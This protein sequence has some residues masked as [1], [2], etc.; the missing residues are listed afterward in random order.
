MKTSK[1]VLITL[2]LFLSII[3]KAQEFDR[4]KM[5]SLFAL[6]ETN[7]K[8]MGSISIFNDGKEAYQNSIGFVSIQDNLKSNRKSK[9]RIGSIS[10]TFTA[11]IIMQLVAK[12]KLSLSSKLSEYYP[13]IENSDGISIE[14][15]LKH[16]SGIFNFTNAED[17]TS[18]MEQPISKE[19]LITK[20]T[21]NGSSFEPNSK[22]EYSNSNYV[23]LSFIA[24]K[25]TS[26]DYSELIQSKICEPCALKNTNYGSFI[27]VK[28][29]EALSYNRLTGWELATE[30]DMSVPVGAGAIISTPT[31]LNLF[32][33][34]L[35]TNKVI[36]QTG[37]D[38]MI[39]I[40]DGYGIGMFKV[41]F[42]D[43]FAFGHTGGIDGFQSNAFYFPN[44]KVSVSYLSNGAV[45]PLN[46]IL[47]GALSIYFGKNYSLPEFAE[48]L[49]LTTEDLDKYL[50]VYS[51]PTFPLKITITKNGSALLAQATGQPY[52]PLEAYEVDK[53]K[54]DQA[55]LKIEFN[56][57]ENLLVLLQG[58][59]TFELKK[60]E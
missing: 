46:D 39:E 57:A 23:L 53:F 45:M 2:L 16:R 50:G 7:Q 41:P 5:D 1:Q 12:N 58:G 4:A 19:E 48:T 37:L 56:P 26:T 29:N 30:T 40:E 43:K 55:M 27:S 3:V 54:F 32:L 33:H 34:C 44:E 59:G 38:K 11:T 28:N 36:N 31:D 22:A 15:L 20:I 10:K 21:A 49:Q 9:Y 18:W 24:E 52:F 47:I 17:Y 42:Y 51:S 35:F 13:E 14:Y 8:G 6:I 25:I 60:E